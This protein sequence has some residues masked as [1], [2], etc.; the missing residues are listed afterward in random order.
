MTMAPPAAPAPVDS[1]FGL[2]LAHAARHG[3]P[4]DAEAAQMLLDVRTSRLVDDP[5]WWTPGDIEQL[6]LNVFPRTV[7]AFD[8]D[9][10]LVPA[11]LR[12]MLTALAEARHLSGTP[13]RILLGELDRVQRSFAAR[14][15]DPRLW[16][17]A[18]TAVAAMRADGVDV[19]DARAVRAW[20]TSLVTGAVAD[21]DSVLDGDPCAADIVLPPVVLPPLSELA[22]AARGSQVLADAAALAV[23]VGRNRPITDTGGLG[24]ADAH[25]AADE[26]G[27]YPPAAPACR[28]EQRARSA[29]DIPELARRWVLAVDLGLVALD[30]R[31]ASGLR[32]DWR[33]GLDDEVLELWVEA[34]GLLVEYGADG[35]LDHLR[36]VAPYDRLTAEL[37]GM[38]A[39][40]LVSAGGLTIGELTDPLRAA[41]PGAEERWSAQLVEGLRGVLARLADHGAVAVTEDANEDEAAAT[42]T[43]TPLGRYGVREQ[44]LDVGFD[45]RVVGHLAHATAAELLAGLES[46]AY[47][48]DRLRAEGDAWVAGRDPGTA[49]EQLLAAAE[50]AAAGPRGAVFGLLLDR[51]A[52]V[53]EAAAESVLAAVHATA[54]GGGL[55]AAHARLWLANA[56]QSEPALPPVEDLRLLVVDALAALLPEPEHLLD[57]LAQMGT[58]QPEQVAELWRVEHPDVLAVLEAVGKSP[59]RA[60]AKAARKA[61]FRCRSRG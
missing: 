27:L 5:E 50:T 23:W 53:S 47:D 15:A 9:V 29:W 20:M 39:A 37:P 34:F 31:R 40:L 21:G 4:F 38:L 46:A 7:S 45:V 54:T 56:N 41:L 25:A 32:E 52:S 13:L 2:A 61:A 43:L 44:L 57:Q 16:G 8:D 48:E 10:E 28:P 11:T 17:P 19:T 59:D 30:G 18:K 6:L 55:A 24:R 58:G 49:A 42:V 22:S 51:V 35:G 1:V 33:A 36:D 14:M 60:V 26:L 12:T 3:L